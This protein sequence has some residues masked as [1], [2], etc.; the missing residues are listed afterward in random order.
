MHGMYTCNYLLRSGEKCGRTC[1]REEGC[2]IHWKARKRYP[3]KKC[4]IPTS[5]KPGLCREHA[6]GYYVMQYIQRLREKANKVG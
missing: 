3:C 4:G 6:G 2:A 1:W 5:A